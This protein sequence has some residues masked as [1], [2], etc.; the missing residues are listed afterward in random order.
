MWAAVFPP[1]K[2]PLLAMWYWEREGVAAAAAAAQV[3]VGFTCKSGA[4]RKTRPS[5]SMWMTLKP[6]GCY[7]RVPLCFPLEEGEEEGGKEEEE[8]QKEEGSPSLC[9][10]LALPQSKLIL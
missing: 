4:R 8:E 5:S 2:F 7:P 9:S 10:G 6:R 1:G 3:R